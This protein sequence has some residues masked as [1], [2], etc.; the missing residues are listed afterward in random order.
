MKIWNIF[1]DTYYKS[2]YDKNIDVLINGNISG[3]DHFQTDLI[4]TVL[5]IFPTLTFVVGIEEKVILLVLYFFFFINIFGVPRTS[6]YLNHYFVFRY[7][8]PFT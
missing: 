5:S 7:F 4:N 2:K 8:K 3:I 6:A 1:L